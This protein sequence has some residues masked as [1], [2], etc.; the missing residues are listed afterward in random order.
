ML[1]LSLFVVSLLATGISYAQPE[2]MIERFMTGNRVPGL[3]V[4][5]VRGDSVLFQ[6]SRGVTDIKTGSPLTA[7][8]CMELGSVSKVFAAETIYSLLGDR[9]LDLRDP[10]RKYFPGA[11]V[12]WSGM[13]IGQLLAHTSGIQN[14]L[15]DPRFKAAAYFS[16]RQDPAAEDFFQRLTPDT[17]VNLFYDLPLEFT[18]GFTWSYSNTGYIL[19]GKIAELVSGKPFFRLAQE[20]VTGPLQMNHTKANEMAAKENCLAKGYFLEDTSLRESRVLQSNY[21]FSAGAWATTGADM[22]RYLK[23][24]HNRELPSDKTGTNW[25]KP[26]YDNALP[27]TYNAGRFYTRFHGQTILSHNGGTPGFSS[28]WIYA[29]DKNTSIIV[30]MNRQDYA[31]I[32]QLAWDLLSF[33]E[34]SLAYPQKKRTGTAE[35]RMTQKVLQFIGALKAGTPFPEGLSKPLA[36]FLNS[37]PGKGYWSWYFERGFPESVQCVDKEQIDKERLYRFILKTKNGVSYTF[38]VLENEKGDWEQ[39]RW[40]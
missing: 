3:F 38:A 32:D 6:Y 27:F 39:L 17:L 22:V 8:T 35:K 24:I 21:A 2:R 13:N 19:L 4:A 20:R 5:V 14:Y 34:P 12:S 40:W 11:P 29:P 15:Q 31:A 36:F 16:N 26:P 25:R 1:R 37:E 9:L 7:T 18:P 23:A 33:F 10:V 28:S 30:L